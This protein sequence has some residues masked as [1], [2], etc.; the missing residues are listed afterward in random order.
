MASPSKIFAEIVHRRR[1][2]GRFNPARIISAPLVRELVD[3][4]LRSPSGFNMQPYVVVLVDDPSVRT[5]V[6]EGMLGAGNAARVREAPLVALFC[7][8]LEALL[9]VREVQEME[10][11]AQQK[12]AS[13]VRSLPTSVAAFAGMGTSSGSGTS[14]SSGCSGSAA[15]AGEAK[16]AGRMA[17]VGA[18]QAFSAFTG[19]PMPPVAAS[20]MA[21]AYKQTGLAAMT[22]MLAATS[23][24]LDTHPMEGHDPGRVAEAVGLAPGRF[25]PALIVAT[26]FGLDG[27]EGSDAATQ[28]KPPTP[29]RTN[30][31]RL[32]SATNPFPTV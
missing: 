13:Y 26:G 28:G 21:W 4:T 32:N 8:D 31:F 5:R 17:L 20:G 19:V 22:Y 27:G 23:L 6:S 10:A 16:N 9:S 3:L 15:A 14:S 1:S 25:S 11:G 2:V 29:R 30:I 24:G 18:V 7:A 12:S